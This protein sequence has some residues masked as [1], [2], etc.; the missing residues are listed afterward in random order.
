MKQRKDAYDL[1]DYVAQIANLAPAVVDFFENV[2][3]PQ[4][5]TKDRNLK[6]GEFRKGGKEVDGSIYE[7]HEYINGK[8]VNN[9]IC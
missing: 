2:N 3:G 4:F 9:E 1:Q 7:V 8:L 6:N 5:L